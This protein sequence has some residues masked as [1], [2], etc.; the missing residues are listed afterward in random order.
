MEIRLLYL[1]VI[2][3]QS[4]KYIILYEK[5]CNVII[6]YVMQGELLNNLQPAYVPSC[7]A[8]CVAWHPVRKIL[9][10]GWETGHLKLW[11][12][13]KD[14][15]SMSSPHS[16]PVLILKW[17]KMG[18]RL[19][20]IDAVCKSNEISSFC[21]LRKQALSKSINIS[22]KLHCLQEYNKLCYNKLTF[23]INSP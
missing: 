7:Q 19:I 22:W 9:V 6:F 23:S 13:E 14:F 21:W 15:V 1:Y 16:T 2:R 10:A 11:S 5:Y 12:G 4:S 17:S 18:G 3:R 20:S 8:L